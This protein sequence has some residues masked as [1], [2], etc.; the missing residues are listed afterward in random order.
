MFYHILKIKVVVFSHNPMR[1][2]PYFNSAGNVISDSY[3]PYD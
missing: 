3:A 1:C 2:F